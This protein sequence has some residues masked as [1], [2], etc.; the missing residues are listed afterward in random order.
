MKAEKYE[1]FE[2]ILVTD[3]DKTKAIISNE[4]EIKDR[5]KLAERLRLEGKSINYIRETLV[6]KGLTNTLEVKVQKLKNYFRDHHMSDEAQKVDKLT[7]KDSSQNF[8]K[9]TNEIEFFGQSFLEGFL[10]F[11]GVELSN[12]VN[13]YEKRI[14]IIEQVDLNNNHKRY[15]LGTIENNDVKLANEDQPLSSKQDA[16]QLKEELYSYKK[17]T[18]LS[19]VLQRRK[20]SEDE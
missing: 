7:F 8:R 12:A 16:E 2:S 19:E 17:E 11:Y 4:K 15:Y 10:D 18:E 20:V 13:D 6:T 3:D 5:E 14:H 9:I 1:E